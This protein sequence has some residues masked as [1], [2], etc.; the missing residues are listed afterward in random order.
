[1]YCSKCGQELTGRFCSNCGHDSRSGQSKGI[2]FFNKVKEFFSKVWEFV[3]AHK[4]AAT[5]YAIAATLTITTTIV[6][7]ATLTNIYRVGKVS[8]I[9]IGMR[10][11]RVIDI[12]G[13]P[14][15]DDGGTLYWFSGKIAKKIDEAERIMESAFMA[16]DMSE[17]EEA[18]KRYDEIYAELENTTYKFIMVKLD[19]DDKVREVFL[20]KK[21]KYNENDDY[22]T[23]PKEI[24][25]IA[26]NKAYIGAVQIVDENDKTVQ[27]DISSDF[28]KVIYSARFKDGSFMRQSC[29]LSNITPNE[30]DDQVTLKWRDEV[31]DYELD[32]PLKP[33][34]K[35][36]E[37][38]TLIRW[39]T[40]EKSITIPSQVSKIVKDSFPSTSKITKITLS[41]ANI[42]VSSNS[43]DNLSNLEYNEYGN[44]KYL[45]T[46]SNPYA[47]VVA[48]I[49]SSGIILRD[50][51]ENIAI[52]AFDD[53]TTVIFSNDSSTILYMPQYLSS[54]ITLPE[55]KTELIIGKAVT[56]I[57]PGAFNNCTSLTS[58]TIPDSVT[59]IG[60]YA[61]QGCS[62]LTSI[63]IPNSVTSIG[64]DAFYG[65]SSLTS[66]TI[67]DSVTSI[68]DYAFQNCSSLTSISIPDSV[69][70]IGRKAFSHCSS[71]TSIT[72]PNS[73]TTIGEYAFYGCSSLTSITIPNSVT[74]IGNSTFYGCSSL[75]SITIPDS[76]T[77]IGYDAFYGCSSLTS[78][79]ISDIAKWCGISFS[80][81]YANPLYF[82]ENLYFNSD[83]ITELLIPDS[84]TSIGGFA[85]SHYSSLMSVTI[86]NS[87][88]SIGGG[89]FSHCSSL[90]SITIP[91]SVT[92][93][94]YDAFYGCSSLTSITIPDSVTSIGE[95]A[96]SG[97]S[98][99]TSITIPDSVTSIGRSA[100][101]GCSSLTS[102]TI[103][104]SVTS[105][106]DYAFQ[107]CSSLTIY[108]KATSKPSGWDF[109]WNDSNCPVVWGYTGEE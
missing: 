31:F 108:C 84:V 8:K 37:D 39:Y 23:T 89:A 66:I 11:S 17:L 70:S 18:A 87:V 27:L 9:E 42:T 99:L 49:N 93:I 62:S 105:I 88:T 65:C 29:Y 32:L 96:F 54:P 41:N 57:P 43:F 6:L 81:D 94:G 109:W 63:T 56:S 20:D 16:D 91:D 24:K 101:Y 103:P 68:G 60:D 40:E 85:F 44:V 78:V 73:V 19:S 12:L 38:G 51:T 74:N 95:G 4:K 10:E 67:P 76:V 5:L 25:K 58:I 100:F 46:E 102:I 14:T 50:D 71:L 30:A 47:L 97:C 64:Y 106:G 33:I 34:A 48:A 22:S 45:G 72:I 82:A 13:E 2:V 55:G 26:L 59:S 53:I 52:G 79:Y 80:G 28:K 36:G 98:S 21:H 3:L 104:N 35:I 69:T 61:F 107:G 75:T 83:L 90:T 77:S 15:L 92:S 1:M 7:I 86:G